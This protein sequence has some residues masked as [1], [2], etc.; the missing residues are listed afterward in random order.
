MIK[1]AI[2]IL[3]NKKAKIAVYMYNLFNKYSLEAGT[4]YSIS[5]TL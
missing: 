2:S 5:P 3:C 1:F 4:F